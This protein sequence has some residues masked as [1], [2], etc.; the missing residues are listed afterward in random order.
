LVIKAVICNIYDSWNGKFSHDFVEH[1]QSLGHTVNVNP[2]WEE[3]PDADINFFYQ[4]DN[5]AIKGTK[6]CTLKGKTFV[7]CVDIE[8]WAGQVYAIDWTKVD[9]A[10]FMANHIED[11]VKSKMT[12]PCKTA[13]IKPGIDLTKWTLKKKFYIEP[14][15][16]K[17]IAYVVGNGRIWDVKRLD[18]VFQ[19]LYDLNNEHGWKFK[20]HIRGTYSTHEQYNAYCKYLEDNLGIK[21]SVVW[22]PDRVEDMNEWLEDKDFIIVPSTKEAFSYATAEAMA[23]GIKPILNNWDGSKRTWGEYVCN[24]PKE[25]RDSIMDGIDHSEPEKY[26][27]FIEDNYSIDRYMKE[28]DE[29]MGIGG[30]AK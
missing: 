30:E 4:A 26:R 20:L 7:H 3:L 9:G 29:F 14:R 5:T 22:Y 18:T 19:L 13:L 25:M 2:R 17:N 15:P 10:I 11:M 1:W 23:K 16:Y 27:K 21:D 8:V 6:E 12:F 28:M 24:S